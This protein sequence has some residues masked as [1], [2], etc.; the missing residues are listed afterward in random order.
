[1]HILQIRINHIKRGDI[2]WIIDTGEKIYNKYTLKDLK[3]NV[4]RILIYKEAK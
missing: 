2:L 3:K 4:S 1:M